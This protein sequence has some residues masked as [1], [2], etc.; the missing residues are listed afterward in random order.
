L[1]ARRTGPPQMIDR[2]TGFTKMLRGEFAPR[3]R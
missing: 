2:G 3:M 1:R